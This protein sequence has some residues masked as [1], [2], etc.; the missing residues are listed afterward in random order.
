MTRRVGSTSLA[1]GAVVEKVHRAARRAA[2]RGIGSIEGLGLVVTL[3]PR[4][5]SAGFRSATRDEG[6]NLRDGASTFQA[7]LYGRLLRRFLV[8]V[9][10]VLGMAAGASRLD[11]GSAAATG[12]EV[13]RA[14]WAQTDAAPLDASAQPT[15]RTPGQS[16]PTPVHDEATCAF[17]QAAIFP[18]CAPQPTRFSIESLG[19]VRQECATADAVAPQF[20]THRLPTTRAP[21]AL[22]SA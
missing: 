15:I 6:L 20:T 18:P 19:L 10:A 16:L 7:M 3:G 5:R 8:A 1:P 13:S 11:A 2:R 12:I 22:R 17:C 4:T 9:P 14:H 21:P